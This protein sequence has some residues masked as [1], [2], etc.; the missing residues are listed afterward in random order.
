[1]TAAYAPSE[2]KSYV[3]GD[4]FG[5]ADPINYADLWSNC[6]SRD[7][8]YREPTNSCDTVV[9]NVNAAC[10][11]QQD[12]ALARDLSEKKHCYPLLEYP[13][14]LGKIH[15]AWATCH[16]GQFGAYF[17]SI[18]DP[19][20][21]LAPARAVGPVPTTDSGKLGAALPASIM[22]S[23]IPAKTEPPGV[24]STTS[25]SDGGRPYLRPSSLSP[26]ASEVGGESLH[27]S[28]LNV[29]PSLSGSRPDSLISEGTM[30]EPLESDVIYEPSEVS[31]WILE[32]SGKLN[33]VAPSRSQEDSKD[34]W[35]ITSKL[36]NGHPFP[37]SN[38][39]SSAMPLT[40]PTE[41]NLMQEPSL[42]SQELSQGDSHTFPEISTL[43]SQSLAASL[44]NAKSEVT[45]LTTQAISADPFT[46]TT[47]TLQSSPSDSIRTS[48]D[49]KPSGT[50]FTIRNPTS[51]LSQ[52]A[53]S[54]PT[55]ST[56]SPT[57]TATSGKDQSSTS[58][59]SSNFSPRLKTTIALDL[60]WMGL[61]RAAGIAL[62]WFKIIAL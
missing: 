27:L 61:F 58:P 47:S 46:A 23:T 16:S 43:P 19:P 9:Y 34:A 39:L 54:S 5:T 6:T 41:T 36:Q 49:K 31:S 8:S 2:I 22:S 50:V 48:K 56:T 25:R 51:D 26:S 29:Y 33:S 1:M 3:T 44:M 38:S 60:K 20:R 30:H 62:A 42:P 59:A 55:P 57:M 10:S 4:S 15:T 40:T 32:S 45:P 28:S 53:L 14:S 24:S 37:E 18:F 21:T 52:A 7:A 13:V 11:T 17:P 35:E 12:E